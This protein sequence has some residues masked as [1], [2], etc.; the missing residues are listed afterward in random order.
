[1]NIDTSNLDKGNAELLE[2]LCQVNSLVWAKTNRLQLRDGVYF[3]LEGMPY[4]DGIVACKKPIRNYK[5]GTQV[6]MTTTN[7]VDAVHSCYYHKYDQNIIYMMPTIN[8]VQKLSQVSFSPILKC[9][10][11]LKKYIG[12]DTALIKSINGRSIIFT[13]AQPQSIDNATDT[14]DS[15]NLRSIPADCVYRD[16]IDLM[17]VDMVDM[18]KQRLN[19]SKF[20]IEINFG[21]PTCPDF[22]IDALYDNSDQ[23][24][25]LIKCNS[26]GHWTHLPTSFPNCVIPKDGRWIR[27]CEKCHAEIFSSDGQWVAKFPD[28]QEAGFWIDSLLT[29]IDRLLGTFVQRYNNCTPRQMLEFQRS[30]LGIAGIEAENQLDLPLVYSRCGSEQMATV[31]DVETVMGVDVDP[32]MHVVIGTKTTRETYEIL[33][34]CRVDDFNQLHDLMHKFNVKYYVI[35]AMPDIHATKDFVKT[36][37]G[38]WRCHYSETMQNA[39]EF[40]NE[41]R[42][43]K[44]NRNEWC[45]KVHDTFYTNKIVIPR[46]SPEIETYAYQ[47]TR[48]AKVLVE[49]PDTGLKKPR[50]IKK[51]GKEDHYYHA[52]LYFLLAAMKSQPV[53]K[54]GFNESNS[55]R[56]KFAKSNF[57]I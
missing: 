3:E 24:C 21:S 4:L 18:S 50:W 36:H 39:P 34:T 7:F 20:G 25:F 46:K 17:D 49:N 9:N 22:G 12:T 11:W 33:H 6:C 37:N 53:R 8:A 30:V 47:L 15:V 19:R 26:C 5:K 38:G 41:E 51:S 40:N 35:D 52:T 13:G 32:Q 42:T 31:S 55:N 56:Y 27:A 48:T 44:C 29:P 10:K 2:K 45:D 43:V 23:Q 16:E 57:H 54:S 14:K 1:M 28:R